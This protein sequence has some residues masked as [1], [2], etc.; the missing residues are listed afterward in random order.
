MSHDLKTPLTAI[1]T[2]IEL[3]REPDITEEKKTEYL[4]ILQRKSNRLKVLIEDLFEISKASS[5]SVTLQIVDVDI[6]NLLRQAYLEQDDRIEAAGLDFKF[7]LPKERI[8]LP[9]DSQKTY[10]IFDN[11]YSNIIKYA[12]SGT[13]VYVN[14][15]DESDYVRVELKNISATELSVAPEELTE[16]FVR[17]DDSR[18]TE[19]SGLGLAIAKSFAE[20]QGGSMQIAI[21]GD[22]FK[23]ILRFKKKAVSIQEE[24]PEQNNVLTGES[25]TF[26][27]QQIP[28][29][30]QNPQGYYGGPGTYNNPSAQNFYGGYPG[31]YGSAQGMPRTGNYGAGQEMPRTGYGAGRPINGSGYGA[32]P[33]NGGSYPGGGRMGTQPAPNTAWQNTRPPFSQ[34]DMNSQ[35]AAVPQ[36]ASEPKG[37]FFKK[38]I[39][40]ERKKNQTEEE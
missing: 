15:K 20:L 25:S 14:L 7:N 8:I 37:S 19:G 28:Y 34:E 12:L 36:E 17:G 10:R 2:Y 16:R 24:K 6:C 35:P 9:L 5:K 38:R 30:V 22:L 39:R 31:M 40:K 26:S 27:R 3:L 32:A 11:L 18:N 29:P 33:Y 21:D 13:R 4:D 1:I 23:V